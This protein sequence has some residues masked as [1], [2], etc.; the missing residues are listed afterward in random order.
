MQEQKQA[1]RENENMQDKRNFFERWHAFLCRQSKKK[2]EW[3][4]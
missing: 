2:N 4:M 1:K 3:N